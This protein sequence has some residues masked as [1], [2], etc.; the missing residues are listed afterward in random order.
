[1]KDLPDIK[2]FDDTGS[3][4]KQVSGLFSHSVTCGGRVHCELWGVACWPNMGAAFVL[5][6]WVVLLRLSLL[7][8]ALSDRKKSSHTF[9]PSLLQGYLVHKKP[10]LGRTLQ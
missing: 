4:H 7:G 6:P 5:M 8:L 2:Y 3:A 10:P 1:M 9:S